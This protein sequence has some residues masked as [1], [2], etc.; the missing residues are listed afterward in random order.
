MA[1]IDLETKI[2]AFD[3]ANEIAE[4]LNK[5]GACCFVISNYSS[6]RQITGLSFEIRHGPISTG[7]YELTAK[8]DR[9]FKV[10]QERRPTSGLEYRDQDRAQ[11]E[12]I[13]WR[14]LL[15]WAKAQAQLVDLG[16]VSARRAFAPYKKRQK[17]N[18]LPPKAYLPPEMM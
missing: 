14:Q 8:T 13:A 9:I 11:A 3:T 12:R 7:H 4:A 17:R 6:N 16:I 2:C 15:I 10:L 5:I 1:N 18:T